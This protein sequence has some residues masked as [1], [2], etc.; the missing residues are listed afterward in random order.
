VR[1]GQKVYYVTERAVFRR[2]AA[3]PTIELIEIAPG[4][5][6]Q[7]DILDQMV[8]LILL[9]NACCSSAFLIDLSCT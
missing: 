9:H 4:V 2:T 3:H 1:R 8:R 6:L 5:D 7:K